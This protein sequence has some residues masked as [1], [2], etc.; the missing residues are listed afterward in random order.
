MG[1]SIL[2]MLALSVPLVMGIVVARWWYK[3]PKR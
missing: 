1:F 2:I 3:G